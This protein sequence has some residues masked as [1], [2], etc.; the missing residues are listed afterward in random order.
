MSIYLSGRL[1]QLHYLELTN[2]VQE[3]YILPPQIQQGNYYI[4]V[5]IPGSK[6]WHESFEINKDTT[7]LLANLVYGTSV[8]FQIKAPGGEKSDNEV[9]FELINNNQKND[10]FFIHYN[11]NLGGYESLPTGSYTLKIFSSKE[12]KEQI[13]SNTR[14]K[15]S[16][17]IPDFICYDGKDIDFSIN[18]NS[19]ETIDLGV[20]ELKP[21]D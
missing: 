17:I 13:K 20:I 12:K 6:D 18:D 10:Y 8:T 19:P 4:S 16:E 2:I 15:C 3:S 11:Y 9:W 5:S 14:G 7:T 1:C 21:T